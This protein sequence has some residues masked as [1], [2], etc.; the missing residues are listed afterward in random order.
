MNAIANSGSAAPVRGAWHTPGT[1]GPRM[2]NKNGNKW[3]GAA[4]TAPA[5]SSTSVQEKYNKPLKR[6]LVRLK[7]IVYDYAKTFPEPNRISNYEYKEKVLRLVDFDRMNSMI[8]DGT[9]YYDGALTVSLSSNEYAKLDVKEHDEACEVCKNTDDEQNMLLCGNESGT[10]GCGKGYHIYC[11]EPKM[12]AIPEGDWFCGKCIGNGLTTSAAVGVEATTSSSV[13]IV[14]AP[15]S[16]I[17][18]KRINW[19]DFKLCVF[20]A[21]IMSALFNDLP[22]PDQYRKKHEEWSAF[23]RYPCSAIN[24]VPTTDERLKW[25]QIYDMSD[26]PGPWVSD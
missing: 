2:L 24:P 20:H 21:I 19:D 14:S 26:M 18:V 13:P 7:E 11:F 16:T 10:L 22:L 23:E 1:D 25:D 9:F 17:Q 15:A 12:E 4:S 5:F 6:L 8:S 3:I